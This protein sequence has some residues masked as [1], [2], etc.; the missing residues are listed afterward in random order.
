[1][2][3]D[4]SHQ[5]PEPRARLGG[6]DAVRV[7]LVA[8]ASPLLLSARAL[9][10]DAAS[11]FDTGIFS[12]VSTPAIQIQTYSLGVVAI[13]AAIFVVVVGFGAWTVIRFRRRDGDDD[14]EPPQIY[15]SNSLELAWTVIPL[16]I[17][18]ILA[19]VTARAIVELQ[20]DKRPAGW[21]A[22]TA[23]GH[24]WWWEFQYPEYGITTANELHIPVNRPGARRATFLTLES[25][26]V[27]HSFWIPRLA[28]KTDIIPN[29]TNHLWFE[30][31]QTGLYVGQCS[32]YCG[33][34]HANMLLRVYVHSPKDF[35]R[36]VREQQRDAVSDPRVADGRRVFLE[37]A[38]IN[39]HTVR[40]TVATGQF[41]PD[42][43]HLMSRQTLGAGV[44]TLDAKTLR[45]WVLNPDHLKPGVRMPAMGIEGESL[46]QLVSYLLSLK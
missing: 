45:A 32:E 3:F 16:V 33:T 14:R 35:E 17:V 37:T 1:M 24:Q 34:Q 12:G 2:P 6:L 40:G 38:C 36:W 39:C 29:R 20:L 9:A 28:G 19:L 5:C 43:T 21:L 42:L 41:G 23:V 8:L 31:L 15:G 11:T 22:V 25:E 7:G 10:D 26:D 30:P 13:C 18:F 44:G 4:R 46:D 27:I